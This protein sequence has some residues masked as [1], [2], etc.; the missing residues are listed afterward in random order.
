MAKPFIQTRL[1]PLSGNRDRKVA[2]FE[3]FGR[4]FVRGQETR[5][6]R[7]TTKPRT[8]S[9]VRIPRRWLSSGDRLADRAGVACRPDWFVS[10]HQNCSEMFTAVAM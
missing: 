3:T 2:C 1:M 10:G 8:I 9:Q 6:Q 7:R 4:G 5:A